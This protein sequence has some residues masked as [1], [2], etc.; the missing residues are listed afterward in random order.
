M[1]ALQPTEISMHNTRL[2]PR[3]TGAAAYRPSGIAGRCDWIAMT[4]IKLQSDGSLRGEGLLRGEVSRSPRTVFLS[5]RSSFHALPWFYEEVLPKI[6]NRFI[7]I[8]GSEDCTLPNQ[9]DARFR[10]ATP[11]E[12]ELVGKIAS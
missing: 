7:L 4:D 10:P 1:T 2:F 11:A 5:M 6:T 3:D 8:S 12:K 9:V